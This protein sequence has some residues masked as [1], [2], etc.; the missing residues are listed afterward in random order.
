MTTFSKNLNWSTI[1]VQ[2]SSSRTFI[3]GIFS[4]SE[5]NLNAKMTKLLAYFFIKISGWKL[6]SYLLC[7]K[8]STQLGDHLFESLSDSYRTSWGH[9]FQKIDWTCTAT[10]DKFCRHFR[11]QQPHISQLLN[12]SVPLWRNSGSYKNTFFASS[13]HGNARVHY[14]NHLWITAFIV[15]IVSLKFLKG[16]GGVLSRTYQTTPRNCSAYN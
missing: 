2:N 15:F 10:V 5:S 14:W 4:N 11:L 3:F 7:P 16:I 9:G 6:E 1:V 12:R 13:N 8:D